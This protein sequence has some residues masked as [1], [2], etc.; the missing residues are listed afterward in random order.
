MV[1]L[2][3]QNLVMALTAFLKE[4][5]NTADLADIGWGV[6]ASVLGAAVFCPSKDKPAAFDPTQ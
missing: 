3:K 1:L 2:L 6:G 5:P 4:G